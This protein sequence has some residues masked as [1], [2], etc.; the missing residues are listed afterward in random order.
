VERDIQ[1]YAA[2]QAFSCL[3]PNEDLSLVALLIDERREIES[4]LLDQYTFLTVPRNGQYNFRKLRGH[5]TT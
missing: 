1:H 5:F 3:L 2:H 4:R